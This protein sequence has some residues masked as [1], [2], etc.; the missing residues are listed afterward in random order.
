MR[1]VVSL[2]VAVLLGCAGQAT[3]K[4]PDPATRHSHERL[5]RSLPSDREEEE[6]ARRGF[7][8]GE[9]ALDIR[10][11]DGSPA[12]ETT[13]DGFL[14]G[15]RPAPA[16][17]HPGLW[18]HARRNALHGLFQVTE[19]VYQVRGYDISN[20]T[21]I[22]GETGYIAVDPLLTRETARAALELFYRHRP[23]KPV[24][25]VLYSHS[26]VDHWG[27]V[28]GI[29]RLED[30]R[31]GKV[32][33][34]A[35]AGFMREALSE[36]VTAGTAMARRATYMFGSLLPRGA[37]G[38]VDAGVGRAVSLGTVGLIPP[39]EEVVR[40]GQKLVIDG[41][42]FVFH[43]APDT[44]APV[45]LNFYLPERR[46]LCIP[47]IATASLHNLLTPRGALVRD[48]AAWARSL[49]EALDLFGD[50][51]VVFHSHHWPRWG[52]GNIQAYLGKQRD[53]YR[54][55][56]DQTVRLMNQGYTMSECAEM[57]QLPPSLAR[58]WYN[59]D[60]YGTVRFNVKAVYQR[61]LG[62][63]DGN[64][65]HLD[66]LPPA[67]A[68]T[69][70]VAFMGGA[71]AVLAKARE[72]FQ[73]G[74]YRW[75][76][77]V[78]NHVVFADP[79]NREA[80]ELQAEALEQ[81]GYQAESPVW[82]NFYLSGAQELREGVAGRG[83]P[84]GNSM[85]VLQ[86]LPTEAYFDAFAVRVNGPRAAEKRIAVDW[87]FTDTNERL[88]VTLENGV[89][90]HKAGTGHPQPDATVTLTRRVLDDI[91]ARNATFAGRLLAGDIRVEGSALRFLEMMSCLDEP[92]PWFNIVT[93]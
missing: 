47:E 51:E 57:I 79:G 49:D 20:I 87:V 9:K 28:M 84:R 64:P 76:A 93:P 33:V 60:L 11:P 70:Y 55:I 3:V 72:S 23:R 90:R 52:R 38:Q 16:T 32:R 18:R 85:D 67:E 4:P 36:N 61:Y 25:A 7:I 44:E 80:R 81:L 6:L 75:V 10:L 2:L 82:R 24:V 59:R 13:S 39:T 43:L 88:S 78:V 29:V 40:T 65:A 86:A 56:H 45:E 1:I 34:I 8:A 31:A 92:S 19:G 63:F 69:R 41:V 54:Y 21:F 37:T 26:H 71:A 27:G 50:A 68:S 83:G 62:W 58:E 12:W 35:P 42:T 15:D 74:D 89:L 53:L 46:A 73:A 17:V 48:G 5:L 91:A 22:E 66:D 14:G 77:Q 30:V